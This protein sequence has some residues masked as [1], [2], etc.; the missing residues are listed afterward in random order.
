MPFVPAKRSVPPLVMRAMRRVVPDRSCFA[1]APGE[2]NV[3][4][5]GIVMWNGVARASWPPCQWSVPFSVNVPECRP[6]MIVVF[7][8]V[9]VPE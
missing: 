8:A 2:G 3:A 4:P 1:P 7:V 6:S 9:I 5:A